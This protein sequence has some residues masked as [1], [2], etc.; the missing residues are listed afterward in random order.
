[1]EQ[2]CLG[3]TGGMG[4]RLSERVG[5]GG[6]KLCLSMYNVCMQVSK[7]FG[8][9]NEGWWGDSNSRAQVSW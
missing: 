1:M 7:R 5:G 6:C 3:G 9:Q 8:A 2:I 4:R